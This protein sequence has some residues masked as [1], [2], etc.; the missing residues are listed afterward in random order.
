MASTFDKSNSPIEKPSKDF[1]LRNLMLVLKKKKISI[2]KTFSFAQLIF[3]TNPDQS[4]QAEVGIG[5]SLSMLITQV[6]IVAQISPPTEEGQLVPREKK[7]LSPTGQAEKQV[8][9][10]SMSPPTTENVQVNPFAEGE[11][12]ETIDQTRIE[13][14]HIDSPP[15]TGQPEK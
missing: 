1:Y 6:T 9:L 8:T 11:Q 2:K 13:V 14:V 12:V 7:V 4:I 10:P 3:L 15:Q 5:S